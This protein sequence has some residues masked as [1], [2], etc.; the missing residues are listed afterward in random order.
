[1][2]NLFEIDGYWKDDKQPFE[3]YIVS[4]MDDDINDDGES[5]NL[6]DENIFF[7]GLTEANIIEA[8]ELGEETIY[9][10]V[11][12]SYEVIRWEV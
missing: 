11:I 12:T 6:D 9:D 1:M 4:E 2:P 3:G 5:D 8:I 10:F 7:Y